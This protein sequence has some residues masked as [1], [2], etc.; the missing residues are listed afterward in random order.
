M[1]LLK[2]SSLLLLV[3]ALLAGCGSTPINTGLLDQARHE[4]GMAQSSAL[5]GTY[6]PSELRLAGEALA[7]ANAAAA[8]NESL[9]KIDHLAYI[10]RQ[11]TATA[12][13]TAKQRSAEADVAAAGH[14][15]NKVLL[16]QRAADASAA[17]LS[18]AQSERAA[19]L[20]QAEAVQAAARTEEAR[21]V[22]EEARRMEAQAKAR[23]DQLATQLADLAAKQ[24]ERGIIITLGDVLF[25]VDKADLNPIGLRT[26]DKL[27][28]VLLQNRERTVLIEGHTD[29]TGSLAHNMDLS[30]RRAEAVKSA[31]RQLGV[32]GDRVIARGFGPSYPVASN[33]TPPNRQLNRRVEI[34]LSDYFGNLSYR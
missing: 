23:A 9:A 33:D 27:A 31:L 17:R 10:A 15:R 26:V 16:D 1:K 34:I 20:A 29:S 32:A 3:A 18:A 11:K 28:F 24:T 22:A 4:Y 21:R 19:Q 25:A 13:E 8:R 14:E 6:A 30:E 2:F 12:R 7:Q 5:V